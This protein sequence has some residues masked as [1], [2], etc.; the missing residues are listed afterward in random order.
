MTVY[1]LPAVNA[2]LN[3][4]A[5]IL[6][7][8]GYLF[9]KRGDI[10]RHKIC[11]ISAF[12]VSALFLACYLFYHYHA[13]S[14]PFQ[15]EGFVRIVYFA[16][17][18]SHTLLAVVNLP[19]ILTTFYRAW[20]QDWERHKRVARWTFPIWMYVSVT[21]VIVYLMLYQIFPGEGS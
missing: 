13:G 6:L 14:R 20:K 4:L 19:L 16:I 17:L 2:V 9:I 7:G 21:G 12:A 5:A 11:M 15:R 18:I 8:C 1:D 3:T 10:H